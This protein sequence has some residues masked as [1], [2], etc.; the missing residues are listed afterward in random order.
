[1]FGAHIDT[2]EIGRSDEE[3]GQ[4]GLGPFGEEGWTFGQVSK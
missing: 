4:T 3:W 2:K 1:V